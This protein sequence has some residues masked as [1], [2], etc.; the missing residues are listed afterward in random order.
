MKKIIKTIIF[1]VT[2][3][4]LSKNCYAMN[5][6]TENEVSDIKV[7]IKTS[8]INETRNLFEIKNNDTNELLYNITLN[9]LNTSINYNS[10]SYYGGM[11]Y[12]SE[13]SR[14]FIAKAIYLG[15]GYQDRSDKK[16]YHITQFI[17]W[18]QL[19]K[20]NQGET[21]F[22]DNSGN[23]LKLYE[24]EIADIKD[25]IKHYDDI[26]SFLNP[27]KDISIKLNEE[28]VLEDTNNLLDKFT[29]RESDSLETTI[30]GNTITIKPKRPNLV[31]LFFQSQIEDIPFMKIFVDKENNYRLANRG[32]IS[33]AVGSV[34]INI[35]SPVLELKSFINSPNLSLENNKY[36]VYFADGSDYWTNI[37]L[38]KDGLSE[39]I[40]M[41][42]GK[43][44]IKQQEAS[45]GYKFNEDKIYFEIGKDDL[46]LDVKNEFITKHV[47]FEHQLIKENQEVSLKINSKLNIYNENNE[48]IQEITT[49]KEGKADI[50]L[51]YGNYQVLENKARNNNPIIIKIDENFNENEPIIIKEEIIDKITNDNS[52]NDKTNNE[53]NNIENNISDKDSEA[54]ENINN[55]TIII[56][57][58]D[59][60]TGK[61]LVGLKYALF[62]QNKEF[63]KEDITDSNGKII[64]KDLVTGTYYLKEIYKESDYN[65]EDSIE[66][67]VKENINTTI[68][69][70][71][72]TKIEVP[73]TIIRSNKF[74]SFSLIITFIGLYN[75]KKCLKN[76]KNSLY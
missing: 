62:N 43:Y 71:N 9:N 68:T 12:L 23:K 26:P 60:L 70:N 58:I 8:N 6:K 40:D 18:E 37:S 36:N 52:L 57:K 1:I 19:A 46:V 21:Y 7:H 28:L 50:D 16:W 33:Q 39:K 22:V 47:T 64:F 55:G 29:M 59:Y 2:F 15:Y 75:L 53:T 48:F 31:S 51:P 5:I 10:Y 30:T 13:E 35:A 45:Y 20:E 32:R 63:I 17:I 67:V 61:P 27:E 25:N 49:N 38:S 76:Q 42:P 34:I 14:N 69:S 66:I 74:S 65:T 24:S 54:N 4:L 11:N 41:N 72:R 44:Y 3:F 73:D 56:N